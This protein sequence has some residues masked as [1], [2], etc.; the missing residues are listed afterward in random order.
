LSKYY[1]RRYPEIL[2]II[3]FLHRFLLS[4]TWNYLLYFLQSSSHTFF[5]LAFNPLQ[6]QVARLRPLYIRQQ[7]AL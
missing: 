2:P 7:Y 3:D 5:V 6:N 1:I 4:F